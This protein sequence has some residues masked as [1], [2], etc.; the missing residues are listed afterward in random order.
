MSKVFWDVHTSYSWTVL[1]H[2]AFFSVYKNN[3][4]TEGITHLMLK[5]LSPEAISYLSS[6]FIRNL[7]F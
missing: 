3:H 5:C 1:I 7:T 2:S 6:T 4:L